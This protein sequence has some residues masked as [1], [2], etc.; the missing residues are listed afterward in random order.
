M[1]KLSYFDNIRVFE[2]LWKTNPDNS[3][4][5][6]DNSAVEFFRNKLITF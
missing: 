6:R 3:Q 1:V 2:L 4:F 5:L